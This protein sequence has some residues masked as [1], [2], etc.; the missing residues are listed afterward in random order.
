MFSGKKINRYI[1]FEYVKIF[2]IIYLVIA[3]LVAIV[4]FLEFSRKTSSINIPMLIKL[5]IVFFEIPKMLEE[6]I[7]FIIILS[8]A[9]NLKTLASRSELTVLNSFGFSLWNILTIYT[10]ITTVIAVLIVLLFNPLFNRMNIISKTEKDIYTNREHN[11]NIIYEKNGFWFKQQGEEN[12]TIISRS[13]KIDMDKYVFFDNSIFIFD[14]YNIFLKRLECA[15]MSLLNNEFLLADCHIYRKEMPIETVNS[16]SIKT[17]LKKD[18]INQELTSKY[19]DIDQMSIFKT[20]KLFKNF[21]R[22]KLNT[23]K[24]KTKLTIFL[25]MPIT[26]FIMNMI[27]CLI[28]N[29]N[30]R[31]IK[32][33][34]EFATIVIISVVYYIIQSIL[35]ALAYVDRINIL[36]SISVWLILNILFY[37]YELIKKIELGNR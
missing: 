31:N 11:K 26:F 25:I 13:A 2:F 30:N 34:F 12:T 28:I 15:K 6:F 18:Y 7:P 35:Y 17:N 21:S 4:N 8:S 24:F 3:N 23:T 29:N 32:S 10:C 37:L 22:A 14:K 33:I 5:K 19:E 1:I 20:I 27:A 36:S 9:I 16:I